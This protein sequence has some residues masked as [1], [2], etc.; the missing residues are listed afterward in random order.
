MALCGAL[1]ERSIKGG[2]II[3]GPLNLGGGGAG[4]RKK[5]R[6]A[7]DVDSIIFL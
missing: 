3:V 2:L 6:H 5:C 4:R 7:A 1:I